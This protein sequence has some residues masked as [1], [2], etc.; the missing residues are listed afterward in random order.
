MN[1]VPIYIG[2]LFISADVFG[3]LFAL[4]DIRKCSA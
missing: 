2:T 4:T 3:I 1:K